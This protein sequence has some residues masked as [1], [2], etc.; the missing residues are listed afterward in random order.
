ME[1][2]IKKIFEKNFDDEIHNDFLKFGR[3]EFRSRYLLEGKRQANKWS[4]KAGPEFANY[5]VKE[6]LKK[7]SGR[8]KVKGVIV[9]TMNLSDEELG[10]EIKKRGN[11]QGIRK[12]EIDTEI[13][14]EKLNN[15][16]NKYP[17][18]F[19]ALSFSGDNFDLKV[20]PKAPKSG[21]PGKESEEGP[22]ADFCSV[23][24]NDEGII[25]ELFFDNPEYKEAVVNHTIFV[26]DIVYPKDFQKMRPEEV[27]E[28]SK[29]KGKIVRKVVV[30]GKES[31]VEAEFVA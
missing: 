20:K 7:V 2:V 1:M 3:G 23:K 25:K 17:R 26:E 13:E 24:T 6:C 21:K 10:F 11:F 9:T 22:R 16:I 5:L 19:Y 27:R 28:Q 29:R 8:V 4:I 12:L 18:V 31:V 14:V 15:L 30:D